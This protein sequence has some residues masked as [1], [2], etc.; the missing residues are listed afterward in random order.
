MFPCFMSNIQWLGK[1][2]TSRSFYYQLVSLPL[3]SFPHFNYAIK[4]FSEINL[5]RKAQF[6]L[7]VIQTEPD[8]TSCCVTNQDPLPASPLLLQTRH[9][10]W[11]LDVL[12][13]SSYFE[14]KFITFVETNTCMEFFLVVLIVS[15][16]TYT[17]LLFQSQ[18]RLTS[19]FACMIL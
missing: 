4:Y 1:E 18:L 8:L 14:L 5:T 2:V 10:H 7:V 15:C 12:A 3:T 6:I 13:F 19:C 9:W 11:R 17:Y 16:T